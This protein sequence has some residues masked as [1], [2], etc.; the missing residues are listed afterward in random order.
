MLHID[1]FVNIVTNEK[2]NVLCR[3][4][5]QTE[6]NDISKYGVVGWFLLLPYF[7][8]SEYIILLVPPELFQVSRKMSVR[9]LI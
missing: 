7:A 1:T 4:Q 8:C 6:V 3:R 9:Y 2:Y 5:Y